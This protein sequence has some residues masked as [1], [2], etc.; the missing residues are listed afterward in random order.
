MPPKRDQQ[1][2]NPTPTQVPANACS[3]ERICYKKF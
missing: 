2:A 1:V 3:L